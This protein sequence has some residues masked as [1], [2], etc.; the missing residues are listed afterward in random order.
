MKKI[1]GLLICML[2][3]V[4][5][6][7]VS[8][9]SEQK[10]MPI[11]EKLD[12]ES[13]LSSYEGFGVKGGYKS[14]KEI[15]SPDGNSYRCIMICN[16]HEQTLEWISLI[17]EF[18]FEKAWQKNLIKLTILLLLPGTLVYFALNDFR[19]RYLDLFIKLVH[20]E[21]FLNLL[22]NYDELEGNG[23]ITYLWL[24]GIIRKPIDFKSQPDDSWV[25]DSWILDEYESYI[26][27]PEIW[28]ELDFWYFDFPPT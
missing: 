13:L 4:T 24:K 25:E 12:N 3:I 8:G 2:L 9:I 21:E 6:I 5:I 15:P 18:G 19:E 22:N 28:V 27:N 20:K 26:P 14:L 10:Q 1:V 17:D 23:I 11:Y 7:P 16:N